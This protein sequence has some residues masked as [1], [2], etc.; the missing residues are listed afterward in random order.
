MINI[1]AKEAKRKVSYSKL[2]V[3]IEKKIND[4]V[5]FG[6]ETT[7]FTSN[8]FD[9]VDIVEV[10]KELEAKGFKTHYSVEEKGYGVLSISWY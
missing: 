1:N 9:N 5:K 6:Y 8:E 4:A 10:I 2:C 3:E 7:S